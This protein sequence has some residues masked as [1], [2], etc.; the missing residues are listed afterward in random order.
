[1]SRTTQFKSPLGRLGHIL[2]AELAHYPGRL[3]LAGRIVIACTIVMILVMV[4]RIP[5]AA[6]GAYYPLLVSR[7]SPREIGRAHV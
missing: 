5:A 6:L 2:R 3:W 4:F 7:E 1:M